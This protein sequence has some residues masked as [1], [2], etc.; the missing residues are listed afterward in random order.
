MQE[1]VGG[2]APVGL[3]NSAHRAIV[4]SLQ[5]EVTA[6]NASALARAAAS[7]RQEFAIRE[8][9]AHQDGFTEGRAKI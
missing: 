3:F 9:N 8:R 1:E 6:S 5:P 7:S 2:V 4:R